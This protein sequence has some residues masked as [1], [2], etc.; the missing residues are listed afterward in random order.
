MTDA[1]Q[2]QPVTQ[3]ATTAS[4]PQS[5]A[6]PPRALDQIKADIATCKAQKDQIAA[7][8]AALVNAGKV[9]HANL[10]ALLDEAD[11]ALAL[12]A[13]EF[14]GLRSDVESAFERAETWAKEHV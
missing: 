10:T 3:A 13:A 2:G 5:A 12:A 4:A 14:K 11:A 9:V 6:Q 1:V 8:K 7:Q